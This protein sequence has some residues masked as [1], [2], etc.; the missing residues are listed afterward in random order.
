METLAARASANWFLLSSVAFLLFAALEVF[1]PDCRERTRVTRRWLGHVSIYTLNAVLGS[2][3]LPP[4][5]FALVTDHA[6][7]EAQRA[8]APIEAWGGPWAVLI[9][10]MA[11]LEVL[12][13]W[14]HRIQHRW[15]PLWRFHA[16]H[17]ADEAMDV[18]TT[19]LHHPVAYLVTGAF[20]GFILLSLGMPAW[21]F[22]VYALFEFAGGVFQHVATPIPDRLERIV[23]LLL[24]T[25]GM[26]QV[27]HSADPAHHDSNYANVFSVWDRLFGTF[28]VLDAAAR[29]HLRFGI[30]G[31]PPV[32]GPVG[33]LLLP[34]RV[35][36]GEPGA[37]QPI[38]QA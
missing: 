2:A 18:G 15:H 25:P 11:A 5:A 4:F 33:S 16:V 38:E 19:L 14:A 36:S 7:V 12:V 22:P 8:F 21:V 9:A 24:V 37:A 30:G 13:Y 34:L 28:V 17:H 3:A 26:H 6:H 10:G 23:R 20:T 27:H 29:E 35:R 31:P 1:R 32:G